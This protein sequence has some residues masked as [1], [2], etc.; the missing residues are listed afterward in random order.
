MEWNALYS[1]VPEPIAF[2]DPDT[3]CWV[4]ASSDFENVI[5]FSC[6]PGE[7]VT[8]IGTET[9][10]SA[11]DEV[12]SGVL[13]HYQKSAK[14]EV[15]LQPTTGRKI[16]AR[17]NAMKIEKEGL[18]L[19]R[20]RIQDL[21]E[22]RKQ[23]AV[24]QSVSGLIE[25]NQK[26]ETENRKRIES[27]LAEYRFEF[28]SL[29]RDLMLQSNRTEGA[30]ALLGITDTAKN[31]FDFIPLSLLE[32]QPTFT[33]WLST[34]PT[35]GT[36]FFTRSIQ[37]NNR[38]LEMRFFPFVYMEHTRAIIIA[39]RDLSDF[40]KLASSSMSPDEFQSRIQFIQDALSLPEPGLV[41]EAFARLN[42][43]GEIRSFSEA[44]SSLNT[45]WLQSVQAFGRQAEPIRYE[46]D[47]RGYVS[48]YRELFFRFA[49]VVR[50][51]A[52]HG[53][54]GREERKAAQ[55]QEMGRLV[56]RLSETPTHYGFEFEDDGRGVNLSAIQKCAEELG[57]LSKGSN[58]KD[59]LLAIFEKGVS[60]R[61]QPG[62]NRQKGMGLTLLRDEVVRLRGSV[63]V[64]TQAGSFTLV[65]VQVPKY[66]P[67]AVAKAT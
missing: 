44:L 66:N 31:L 64:E 47:I 39:I 60:V 12:L 13:D 52:D 25:K 48:P 46:N 26:I 34:V 61:Y 51:A 30:N 20:I 37:V 28:L 8:S 49:D 45:T 55:K 9:V 58:S 7:G 32:L 35:P 23:Q 17:I 22:V 11:L 27:I 5:G 2:V 19:L 50:N 57:F 10:R 67:M 54:E 3:R 1:L 14:V 29:G 63:G 21:S 59:T 56:I 33:S 40:K 62:V 6:K 41:S 24:L 53:L 42:R 65:R 38:Y 18:N 16:S 15:D 4:S 43:L 36:S